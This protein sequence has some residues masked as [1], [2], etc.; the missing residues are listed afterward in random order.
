VL[1]ELG[2]I[3]D[4]IGGLAVV[5]SLVYLASQIR[6]NTATV[7]V[8]TVQHLLT[9]DTTAADSLIDGPMPEILGKL[10][11]EE[12][13]SPSE[14]AA[15]T[16]YMR[17]RLTEAWQVLYQLRNGMIE[18]ELAEA[19]LRRLE[20]D[21]RYSL[22]RAVWHRTI[23]TGFPR[24]FQEYVEARMDAARSPEPSPVDGIGAR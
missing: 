23:R 11:A 9:S 7:R 14:I 20:T 3:G 24:E 6:Q 12:K 4:F 1:N 2:N 5:L 8:Q 17:G 21:L 16:L 18:S 13:L 10:A 19:L 22:F 15:Y